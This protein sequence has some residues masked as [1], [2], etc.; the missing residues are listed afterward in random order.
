MRTFPL[1]LVLLL[2]C[3][4]AAAQYS[5]PAVDACL[6]YA[7]R[8]LPGK[9]VIFERNASL[10]LDRYTKKA[11]S[12]FVSSVLTGNGAVAL[13]NSPAVELSFIC[14][15]AD[16]KRPVFFYWLPRQNAPAAMQCRR[17][18]TVQPRPCLD[19]LH[20][21]AELDLTQAYAERYQEAR[22][23]DSKSGGEPNITA[24]R[25]AG[26]AWLQYRAAECARQRDLAP[27]GMAPDDYQVA[28]SV[29]LTRR[30]ALDMR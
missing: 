1:A 8:D 21:V 28:C 3:A 4:E 25:K 12:Q 2:A 23:R 18:K 11:G 15:L 5:G 22:E 6:A 17:S 19:Y 13:E 7:R 9:E 27:S 26:E 30:R 20:Q 16:E 10:N 14:L 24:F 29:D